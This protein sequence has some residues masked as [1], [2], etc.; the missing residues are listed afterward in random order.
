MKTTVETILAANAALASMRITGGTPYRTLRE[1]HRL[2]DTLAKEVSVACETQEDLIGRYGGRTNPTGQIIF[3]R[4]EDRA[5]FQTEWDEVLKTEI[6]LAG[7]PVDLSG[8]TDNIMFENADADLE[9]LSA[10][11][12]F[13][14]E[15][16]HGGQTDH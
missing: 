12:T 5:A 13:E 1:L 9:S 7:E 11:I 6:D 15:G 4:G 10:F 16:E 2:R 3:Q 8:I 14:K